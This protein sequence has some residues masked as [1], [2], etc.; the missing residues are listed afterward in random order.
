MVRTRPSDEQRS[1]PRP[2]HGGLRSARALALALL[3]GPGLGACADSAV[4]VSKF[5]PIERPALRLA[6]GATAGPSAKPWRTIEP[7]AWAEPAK[8]GAPEVGVRPAGDAFEIVALHT[9]AV[10]DVAGLPGRQL[11]KLF[12]RDRKSLALNLPA[13]E[14]RIDRIRL[15]I[16]IARFDHLRVEWYRES[17]LVGSSEL[18]LFPSESA[19]DCTIDSP[20]G[21][22]RDIDRLVFVVPGEGRVALGSIEL[23]QLDGEDRLPGPGAT[24]EFVKLG[25][26][27]RPAWGVTSGRPLEITFAAPKDGVLVA[28]AAVPSSMRIAADRPFLTVRVTG[29]PGGVRLHR[30]PLLEADEWVWVR[31]PLEAGASQVTARFGLETFSPREAACALTQPQVVRYD[32]SAPTVLLITSDTH[33]GDHV[34]FAGSGVPVQTPVLDALAAEGVVFTDAWSATNVTIPSHA[35][36]FTGLPL[37]DT[38]VL[39]NTDALSSAAP[40]L[41]EAFAAAGYATVAAVSASHVSPDWSGLGQGFERVAVSPLDK[42]SAGETLAHLERWL[43]DYRGRPLFVWLHLFDA[44]AT[45]SPPPPFNTIA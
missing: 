39:S 26:D 34:G 36:I 20:S 42:R 9:E 6:E 25:E 10:P 19:A 18:P 38:H 17:V 37:R 15:R 16:A 27:I 21:A 24:P 45:Y 30:Y 23:L 13:S 5:E 8:V 12:G 44:H 40:T 32:E 2:G 41:A 29:L 22:N 4:P 43:P 28:S 3:L 31:I 35:A 14:K 33:R 11:L 7:A 1:R